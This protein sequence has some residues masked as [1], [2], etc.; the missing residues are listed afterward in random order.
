MHCLQAAVEEALTA[1]FTEEA[2]HQDSA[3]ME[4]LKHVLSDD[5]FYAL[6]MTELT[7]YVSNRKKRPC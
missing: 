5:E 2:I 3:R 7:A 6:R 4:H 1:Y